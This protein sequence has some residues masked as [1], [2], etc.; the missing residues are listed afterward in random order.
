MPGAVQKMILAAIFDLQQSHDGRAPARKVQRRVL[1][2]F[3]KEISPQHCYVDMKRMSHRG[4][5]GR[6]GPP[7]SGY[8]C[9]R[10]AY[11]TEIEL[12]EI[13]TMSKGER[14]EHVN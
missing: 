4:I 12:K 13:V 3:G 7:R 6:D 11:L 2:L 5:L 8:Y 9:I 10:P 14:R 1:E